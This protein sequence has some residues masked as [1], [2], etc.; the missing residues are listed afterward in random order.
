MPSW[1]KVSITYSVPVTNF[2]TTSRSSTSPN[3]L[4]RPIWRENT[5]RQSAPPDSLITPS[6]LA[7][8]G[9]LI[10]RS[11]PARPAR[12]SQAATSSMSAVQICGMT[13]RP[14]AATAAAMWLLSRRAEASSGTLQ[15][16]GTTSGASCSASCT[17]DSQPASTHRGSRSRNRDAT[18]S[19]SPSYSMVSGKSCG[20]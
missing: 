5:A 10:T 11:A 2:C 19:R 18:A 8:F 4:T 16:S 12:S 17:P 14:A 1:L 3:W 7:L 15:R 6:V 13:G 9:G 20:R